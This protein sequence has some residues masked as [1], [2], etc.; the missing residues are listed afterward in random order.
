MLIFTRILAG[1]RA[2][3]VGNTERY[4][5][6]DFARVFH[7]ERIVLALVFDNGTQLFEM[8]L[9][10]NTPIVAGLQPTQEPLLSKISHHTL[11]ARIFFCRTSRKQLFHCFFEVLV[12]HLGSA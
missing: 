5:R 10:V 6:F 1:K 9:I 2:N 11:V 3:I 4:K 12:R 7:K 8:Q